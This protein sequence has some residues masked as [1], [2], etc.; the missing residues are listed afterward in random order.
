MDRVGEIV[1]SSTYRF[2]GQCYRL[3]E[4]PSLGVLV[5]TRDG[6][7]EIFAVVVGAET[8]GLEPGRRPIARGEFEV[9]EEAVFASNP[10]LAK[11]LVTTFTAVVVGYCS[12]STVHYYLPERPARVHSFVY[13]CDDASARDFSASAEFV[14]L[15]FGAERELP[16]DEVIAASLR[17]LSRLQEDPERFLVQAGK[18]LAA[19]VGDDLQRLNSILKR[20]V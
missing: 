14:D 8:T 2:V 18:R 11:L 19:R 20:L 6:T 9:T 3:H 13:V 10:Q 12:A 4:P 16:V 5:K 1:E 7:T 17:Y 15:L